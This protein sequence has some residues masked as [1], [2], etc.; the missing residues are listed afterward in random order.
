[1][2]QI[3]TYFTL[4]ILK[5]GKVIMEMI[6]SMIG[7]HHFQRPQLSFHKLPSIQIGTTL[8]AV[9]DFFFQSS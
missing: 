2:F 6:T 9:R 7:S 5:G 8:T 1:M 3:K 4:I